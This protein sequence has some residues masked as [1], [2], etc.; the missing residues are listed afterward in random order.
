MIMGKQ[1]IFLVLVEILL[2]FTTPFT[3]Y[4]VSCVFFNA[5]WVK[6]DFLKIWND[7][8]FYCH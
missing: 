2:Y 7:T 5:F 6:E 4:S 8:E 3:E 1:V